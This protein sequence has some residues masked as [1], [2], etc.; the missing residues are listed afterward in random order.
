MINNPTSL[1]KGILLSLD[2][3]YLV[4]TQTEIQALIQRLNHIPLQKKS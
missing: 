4:A 2:F 1:L 3:L